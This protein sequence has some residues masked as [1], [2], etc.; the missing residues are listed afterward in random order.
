MVLVLLKIALL[1]L[2]KLAGLAPNVAT[3]TARP[4]LPPSKAT[5]ILIS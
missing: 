3:M 1:M 4:F 2:E 5:P